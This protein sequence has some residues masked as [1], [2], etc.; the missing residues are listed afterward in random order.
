[1]CYPQLMKLQLPVADMQSIIIISAC[2]WVVNL[3]DML[4]YN[5]F[6]SI[7]YGLHNIYSYCTDQ[8]LILHDL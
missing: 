6:C 7:L 2:F 1:M 5:R 4:P 8:Y 3:I